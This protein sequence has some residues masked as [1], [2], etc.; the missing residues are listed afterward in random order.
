MAKQ[1]DRNTRRIS[2]FLLSC[3]CPAVT[4]DSQT[5]A[6]GQFR[7]RSRCRRILN[8]EARLLRAFHKH[9]SSPHL[10]GHMISPLHRLFINRSPLSAQR[11][12][13]PCSQTAAALDRLH[14][15]RLP[16]DPVEQNRA[17]YRIYKSVENDQAV[18]QAHRDSLVLRDYTGLCAVFSVF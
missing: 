4:I 8:R 14:C 15:D 11:S 9:L 5:T 1:V 2:C 7:T 12:A 6:G 18:R 17:C 3:P 13:V 16:V 10:L